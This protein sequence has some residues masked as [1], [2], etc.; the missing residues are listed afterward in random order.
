MGSYFDIKTI[1]DS[2]T[3]EDVI[4]I[5]A[6]LGSPE[7]KVGSSGELIFKSICHGSDSWKLYYYHEPKGKYPGRIFHCYSRCSESFSIFELVVRARKHQGIKITFQQAVKYVASITNKM[8]YVK[9]GDESLQYRINDWEW[10]NKLKN[11]KKKN[12]VPR[13]SEISE[14]ILDIFSYYPHEEWLKEGISEESMK[15]YQ[16]SY[17]GKENKIIIPHR[18]IDGRLIGIRGRSLNEDEVKNGYKYMPINIEGKELSHK[19]GSNLYGLCQNEEAIRRIGKIVLFE[20]EKSVL[21][22][23]TFYHQNNFSVAVCGSSIS[24][25]QFRIIRALGV[26]EVMIA[27][28]KEYEDPES[29]AAEVYGNKLINLARKFTPYFTVY[30]LWD[31]EGLLDMK[32][33]PA[34]KGKEILE[35][36]MKQKIEIKTKGRGMHNAIL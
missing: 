5:A 23:D 12:S 3:K 20:S 18:D 36:L 17:W 31:E 28:D 27:F 34:D 30:L 14:H 4:K 35:K 13:L 1:Q 32:D 15:K 22:C 6:E 9:P 24:D 29:R 33:S 10:I 16:I 2:I 21:L 7:Y 26:R 11:I 19:L 25:T 8:F